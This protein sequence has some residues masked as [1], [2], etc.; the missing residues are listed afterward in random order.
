MKRKL[1]FLTALLTSTLILAAMTGS[2]GADIESR[3]WLGTT[4]TG[5]DAFYGVGYTIYAYET[6]SNATLIV[7]V[8]NHLNK[9]MNVSAIK[10]GFDWGINYS[11]TQAS[12]DDPF[13]M[14]PGEIRSFTV[15]FTVPSTSVASNRFLHGYEIY[16]EH[17][18]STIGPK[19]VFELEPKS[20]TENPDF[21]VYSANQANA[22][23]LSQIISGIE[24]SVPIQPLTFNS[25]AARLLV[26][27]AKNETSI[28][29]E[30]Y[31][32]GNFADAETHYNNA[33]TLYTSAYLMEETRGVELEDLDVEL[34]RAQINN[35]QAWA[36]M[37]SSLST[38]SMLL[39][40]AIVLF[41]IGYIIKQLGTL[42]K[43]IIESV[44]E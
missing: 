33:L 42:R 44:K 2:L 19:E 1:A 14:D 25:T 20:Y 27:K 21:A 40:L 37:V 11:S 32:R 36:S 10:V 16:V 24:S 18:N 29:D 30:N 26:Y 6:G 31:R 3:S 7:S 41:G 9:P 22:L 34:V 23:E 13:V 35:L 5:I 17:V 8:K 12:E 15:S 28:G 38:T 39:G 4:Y 43:P